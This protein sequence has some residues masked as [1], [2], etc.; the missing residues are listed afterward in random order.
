M[1]HKLSTIILKEGKWYVARGIEVEIA[2]QGKTVEEALANLRE[3][4]E[5]WLEHAEPDETA[6]LE[7]SESPI[8]T[9]LAVAE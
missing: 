8:V 6:T 1:A 4:F 9:Q 3:A 5:L 7:G 2:S